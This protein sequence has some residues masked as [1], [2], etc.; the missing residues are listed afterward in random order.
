MRYGCGVSRILDIERQ[1]M[2]LTDADRAKLAASLLDSLPAVLA[3]D[4]LGVEEALR[5]DAELDQ[6]PS[7]GITWEQLCRSVGR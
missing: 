3:E 7:A 6:D 1:A 2:E 4:D 5:R